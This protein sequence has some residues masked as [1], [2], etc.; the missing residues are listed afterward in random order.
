MAMGIAAYYQLTLDVME[1]EA[2]LVAAALESFAAP[3]PQSVSARRM[4]KGR[5][6]RVEA[7]FDA[8]PDEGALAAF[9]GAVVPGAGADGRSSAARR[10]TLTPLADEDWVALSQAQLPPIRTRR[11]YLR[12]PHVPLPE[13]LAARH[14]ITIEA[15]M[16]FG[17]GHHASTH[18]CLLALESLQESRP[19]SVLD[20]GTGTGLL[21]IAATKLWPACRATASDIDP[22]AIEVARE[23]CRLNGAPGIACV[24]A[25]GFRAPRLAGRYDLIVANI[26]AAPLRLLAREIAAHTEPRGRVILSGILDEQAGEIVACYRLAGFSL[27]RRRHLEGWAMLTF[28]RNRA[29]AISRDS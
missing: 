18:G 24:T 5:P 26:L 1:E 6:W 22:V 27:L 23:N 3:A 20:L 14:V 13:D 17:T 28:V 19:R 11:F 15:G 25:P 7:I 8:A 10:F 9:L 29:R 4:G 2:Q 16:A 21:A 12:G